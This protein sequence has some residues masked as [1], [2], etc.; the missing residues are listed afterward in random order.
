MS[1]FSKYFFAIIILLVTQNVKAQN[2]QYAFLVHFKD[3]AA[4]TFSLNNPQ[5]YLSA[6]ALERRAKYNITID[7]TDL[8]VVAT[9]VDSIIEVTNG[10]LHLTSR[11]QNF[12]VILVE[13]SASILLLSNIDFVKDFRLVGYYAAGLHM[14]PA[15]DN[16][17]ATGDKPTDFDEN[18]YGAAWKQIHLC[19]G[20]YLHSEGWTGNDKLIAV[21]DAGFEG[22][23]TNMAFDSLYQQGRLLDTH[24]FIL[25]TSYVYDYS[26]HGSVVLSCMASLIP[27]THV[28]TAPYASYALY[29]TDDQSTEQIIEESNFVAATERADSIGADLITTSLGY[30]TFDDPADN[31]TYAELDGKT[32]L[33]AK[34]ANT[35]TQKGIVVLASAGNEGNL[36]WEY[37][38]TPGDADSAMTIGSVNSVKTVAA[39]S[40]HGPNAAGSLPARDAAGRPGSLL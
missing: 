32:T 35:A 33:V 21:I 27:E 22:V 30:N 38:L 31:H 25:D 9:Y 24:N 7:S 18:Y 5:Q 14:L 6:R 20:E 8:P 39:S 12:A 23:N 2:E 37:I 16:D 34:A 26:Q 29:A 4:T 36:P 19:N 28:G 1:H 10:V 40:G 15:P 3:K 17:S 11:W 13:D